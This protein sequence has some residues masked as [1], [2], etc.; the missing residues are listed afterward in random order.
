MLWGLFATEGAFGDAAGCWIDAEDVDVGGFGTETAGSGTSILV[1]PRGAVPFSG[2]WPQ[3]YVRC[4]GTV[5]QAVVDGRV[6]C[7]VLPWWRA[8]F[9][10]LAAF[11][12]LDDDHRAAAFGTGLAQMLPARLGLLIVIS[13]SGLVS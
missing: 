3:G 8:G 4:R 7:D 9:R 2:A 5:R 12:C 10:C 1:Q 11:E 13:V 6:S